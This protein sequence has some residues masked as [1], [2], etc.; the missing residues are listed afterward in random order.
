MIDYE[1]FKFLFKFLKFR[2]IPKKH[3]TNGSN[4]ASWE[5]AK[6]IDNEVKKAIKT[7][8]QNAKFVSLICD[9]VTSM[10]NANWA[11]VHG[12]IVQDWCRILL[13]LSV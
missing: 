2:F 1:Y 3:L 9:K 5:M 12:Y 7:T 11:S 6:H 10:D 8:I 13:L 4:G